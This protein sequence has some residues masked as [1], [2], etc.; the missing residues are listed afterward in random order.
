MR[1]IF[2]T[3]I[4]FKIVYNIIRVLLKFLSN[5]FFQKPEYILK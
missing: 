4:L 5:F 3:I 1:N 2:G